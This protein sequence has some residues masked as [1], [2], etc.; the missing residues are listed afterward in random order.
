MQSAIPS[1]SESVSGTPQ[2][3]AP[4]ATLF[5][6]F[7]Q[8]SHT[9]PCPSLSSSLWSFIHSPLAE[10]PFAQSASVVQLIFGLSEVEEQVPRLWPFGLLGQLSAVSGTP[11]PSLSIIDVVDVLMGTTVVEVVNAVEVVELIVGSTEVVVDITV[12]VA[13]EVDV[14]VSIVVVEIVL[15]VSTVEVVVTCA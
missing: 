14:V 13:M 11:S 7:G 10:Q 3:H 15:V 8:P 5:G 2:P 4:G 9:S 12:V 1:L 6:S